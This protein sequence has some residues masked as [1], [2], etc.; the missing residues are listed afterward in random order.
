MQ[1]GI[2]IGNGTSRKVKAN[3]PETYEGFKAKAES[4][5]LP[6]DLLFNAD[7]WSQKPDFLNKASLL[8]DPTCDLL[9]I[10]RT[11][12][13]N[14]AFLKLA[15]GPGKYGYQIKVLYPDGSPVVGATVGGISAIPG[16]NLITNENGVTTGISNERS[17]TISASFPEAFDIEAVQKAVTA[18]GTL[19]KAEVTIKFKDTS[20]GVLIKSSQFLSFSAAAK[21]IDLTAVGGGGGGSLNAGSSPP[22][23]CGGGGGF[24][25]HKLKYQLTPGSKL[26]IIVGASG[27]GA[28]SKGQAGQNGGNTQVKVNG[29]QILEAP[30]GKGGT[31]VGGDGCGKGG[32]EKTYSDPAELPATDCTVHIFDESSL[33]LAGSGGGPV[34]DKTPGKPNGG[35]KTP[36][37]GGTSADPYMLTRGYDGGPGGVWVRVNH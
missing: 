27:K 3:F 23:C 24:I 22:R 21:T 10:D 6:L 29:V 30:G 16:Q 28:S 37:G 36:G 4:G 7:G 33:P 11:S 12:T 18:T 19:T 26:Q 9:G 34:Y 8:Q 15:L 2:I 1:D 31:D 17:V 35:G 20:K 5:E 13:V 32:T 25:R 14:D